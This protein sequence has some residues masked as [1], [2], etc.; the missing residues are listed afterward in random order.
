[1]VK[2]TI[3]GNV[4]SVGQTKSGRVRMSVASGGKDNTTW[5]NVIGDVEEPEVGS[6]V[7]VTGDLVMGEPYNGKS[8]ATLFISTGLRVI[9]KREPVTTDSSAY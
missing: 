2:A 8:Q 3:L 5:F 4:G 6:R 1:M 7:E 9:P